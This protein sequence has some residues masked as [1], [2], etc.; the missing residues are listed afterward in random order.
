MSAAGAPAWSPSSSPLLIPRLA[1]PSRHR[2][3]FL[4][5]S[6]EP[7]QKDFIVQVNEADFAECPA[8]PGPP[9]QSPLQSHRS[10]DRTASTGRSAQRQGSGSHVDVD[11]SVQQGGGGASEDLAQTGRSGGLRSVGT[12][13]AVDA[14]TSTP[15]R[16]RQRTGSGDFDILEVERSASGASAGTVEGEAEGDEPRRRRRR[17]RRRGTC[18]A[19]CQTE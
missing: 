19:S 7:A 5:V 17:R 13:A 6:S 18:E 4:G 10:R 15:R 16:Q 1:S 2:E 3:A 12:P 14:S 8:R 11:A 9:R